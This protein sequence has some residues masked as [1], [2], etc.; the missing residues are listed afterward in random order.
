MTNRRRGEGSTAE[1]RVHGGVPTMFL[2][3]RPVSALAY[4]GDLPEYCRDM[5]EAGLR[6]NTFVTRAHYAFYPEHPDHAV[7]DRRVHEHDELVRGIIA[8]WPAVRI[9]PRLQ[10]EAPGWWAHRYPGHVARHDAGDGCYPRLSSRKHGIPAWASPL[11]REQTL[12]ALRSYIE[13]VRSS[14][15]GHRFVGYHLASGTSAEWM[16]FGSNAGRLIDY[17]EP[18]KRA[19]RE[20]LRQRYRGDVDRL[21]D[22]WGIGGVTFETAAIPSF[23][24]RVAFDGQWL[25]DPQRHRQAIDYWQFFSEM[26]VDTIRYLARGTKQATDRRAF[27]GVFYGYILQLCNEQRQQNAGHMAIRRLLDC[28]D[29]DFVSSPSHY[30]DRTIGT[31][32]SSFM[33]VAES[34]KLHG[35]L[36]YNENDFMS[37]L[38]ERGAADCCADG[39][40]QYVEVQKACYASVLCNGVSQ[41]LLGFN[42]G[43]YHDPKIVRIIKRQQEIDREALG[44][45]RAST[46]EVAIIVDDTSQLHQPVANVLPTIERDS[47]SKLLIYDL[48]PRVGRSGVGVDWLLLDDLD[49]ARPYKVY[50]V[51]NAFA[52]DERKRTLLKWRCRD[53]AIVLWMYA[54]GVIGE[55]FDI[56][57]IRDLTGM[58]V[59]MSREAA[60]VRVRFEEIDYPLLARTMTGVE[61]MGDVTPIAPRFA[62]EAPHAMTLARYVHGD[63]VAMAMRTFKGWTSVY[64]ASPVTLDERFIRELA[65]MGG[66]HVYYEGP[67]ATYIGPGLIAIHGQEAGPKRIRL[68]YKAT[69]RELYEDKIVAR[70]T[71][72]IEFEL[73][74]FETKLFRFTR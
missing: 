3:G 66:V 46:N 14:D 36:W 30:G 27:V 6:L 35:K 59:G 19:F 40:D 26:T 11:W 49:Q 55:R 7:R 31:G 68:P 16:A 54:P 58:H 8:V 12:A 53:G 63:E 47:V 33:S 42:E 34:V 17:G 69:V 62:I 51:L 73:G 20:W 56:D 45:D 44:W 29:V 50:I 52:L 72:V 65:R 43:W 13:H 41:W 57:R 37:P 70:G 4:L 9:F 61:K 1:V 28:P 67:D 15:F 2:D 25:L 21:R 71:E 22:A 24:R 64:C 23:A 74:Q 18:T 5:A 60:P 38:G 10:L 48:P 32:Y 39:V